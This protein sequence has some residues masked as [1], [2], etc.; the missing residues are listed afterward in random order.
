MLDG[1]GAKYVVETMWMLM[2]SGIEEVRA[3]NLSLERSEAIYMRIYGATIQKW[4]SDLPFLIVSLCFICFLFTDWNPLFFFSI[5][6]CRIIS[7]IASILS[8]TYLSLHLRKSPTYHFILENPSSTVNIKWK[9]ASKYLPIPV[10][11]FKCIFCAF[12]KRYL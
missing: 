12:C 9:I 11:R 2:E 7:Q 1:K 3:K 6:A 5:F 10:P 8:L 4:N